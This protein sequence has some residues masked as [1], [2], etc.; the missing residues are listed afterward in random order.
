MV[1]MFYVLQIRPIVSLNESVD[2]DIEQIRKEDCII[3]ADHTLGNG[4]IK[5][6]NDFVY[7][8]PEAFNPA[9]TRDIAELV[10]KLN[11]KFLEEGKYYI[12]V[13]PGRW[14]SSDP[15][16]GIPV[17][18]PQISSA[19]VIIESGLENYRIDPSQGTHFFQNLTS[20]G[21]GYFTINPFIKDGFYD[22]KFLEQ[23]E[24]YYED[25][26][27]RHIRFE[28]SLNIIIDGRKNRG[29][30]LKPGEEVP[31]IKKGL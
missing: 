14:G 19:R 10:G 15:W 25:D 12:L 26:Y 20:F 27:I 23:Q 7:V 8:K 1:K 13:G 18:W 28:Q 21:V 3:T 16:L 17:K 11:A 2:I 4:L 31:M 22:L 9:K 29:M 5:G 24:V 30:I 6:I